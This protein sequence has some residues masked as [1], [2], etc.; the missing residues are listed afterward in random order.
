MV[1][2]GVVLR[3]HG[4]GEPSLGGDEAVTAV[5]ARGTFSELVAN[6][7]TRKS[8]P[9]LYP[10]LLWLVQKIEISKFSVRFLP[11]AASS[12]TVAALL[13]L[14]PGAGVSRRA[15]LLAGLLSALSLAALFQSHGLRV[16]SVDALV[17]ALLLVGLLRWVRDGG[18]RGLLAAGLF[19]GPLLQYGLV[20]FGV[21]VLAT[22]F[23][24]SGRG[25]RSSPTR[26]DRGLVERAAARLRA[27]AGL[28]LPAA[29]F[30]TACGISYLTTARYQMADL[31]LGLS[32]GGAVLGYLS[33]AYWDGDPTDLVG[34]AAFVASRTWGL[35][36]AHLAPPLASVTLLG[37]GGL[38]LGFRLARRGRRL[39]ERAGEETPPGAVGPLVLVA[40]SFAVAA[41]AAAIGIYPFSAGRHG[42]YLGPAICTAAGALLAAAVER[43][44]AVIPRW[45]TKALYAIAVVGVAF[46]GAREI[47]RETASME[48]GT[49]EEVVD[50]LETEVRPDDLVWVVGHHPVGSLEFYLRSL[51]ENYHRT[52]KCGYDL[53]CAD[54]LVRLVRSLPEP[55]ERV[56]LVTIEDEGPWFSESLR[57]WGDGIRLEPLVAEKGVAWRQWGGDIRLYRV[58]GPI[59]GEPSPLR[60]APLRDY[61]R[62]GREEPSVLSYWEIWRREDALVYRRAPCSAADTETRFFLEFHASEEATAAGRPPEN[63][64]FD[65]ENLGIRRDGG[66]GGG[67]GGG[68]CLAIVPIPIEGFVRFETGQAGRTT[69]WR[70]AGRLDDERWRAML[71]SALRSIRSGAWTPTARSEFALY[72][73]EE[74][75][76]YYRAPCSRDDLE[77][78]FF[79]H[80]YPRAAADLPVDQLEHGFENRDFAFPDRGSLLEEECLARVRLPD[81]E[82]V[83]LRTGQF[84]SGSAP[85][86]SV[87]LRQDSVSPEK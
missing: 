62:P 29:L 35:L 61:D 79:L 48:S 46:I 76:W 58:D 53:A 55:P 18:G 87:E 13:T 37:A 43:P 59:A 42:V 65:F 83:R 86:W 84:R 6:M 22:G 67:G 11:A 23:V 49:V 56:F 45:P 4:L 74:A 80:I 14:L 31:G 64:D 50:L 20:L 12:L 39:G 70:A 75:L 34:V 54:E 81:Y 27:G 40:V 85:L 78:R 28:L 51:P 68:E 44:A 21:A 3:F 71:S 7:H 66:G 77:A 52:R 60:A 17:A 38:L 16:Y 26:E 47:R 57:G 73:T 9:F 24:L 69:R 41:G 19:L 5:N 2:I 63:R 15:A 33:H 72:S 32:P 8:T 36:N 25:G 82:I 1:L 10:L 30:A